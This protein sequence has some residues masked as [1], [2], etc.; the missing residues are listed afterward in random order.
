MSAANGLNPIPGLD[1][2]VDVSLLISMAAQIIAAYGLREDQIN[3][4]ASADLA[5]STM[6]A[7]RQI[8]KPFAEYLAH[9]AIVLILKRLGTTFSAKSVTKVVPFVGQ[10][11]AASLG[12]TLT[13][14]F[15]LQLVDDC[16]KAARDVAAVVRSGRPQL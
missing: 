1:I 3:Y 6:K 15:G 7:I 5:A 13:R 10:A 8:A 2:G 16:E 9:E 14:Y 11:V 4:T 12:F